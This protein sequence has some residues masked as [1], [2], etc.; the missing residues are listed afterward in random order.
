MTH[1]CPPL[2]PWLHQMVFRVWERNERSLGLTII[3]L[4]IVVM[5]MATLA[6]LGVPLYANALDN[7]VRAVNGG[8]VGLSA[9]F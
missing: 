9:E 5:I 1:I 7:V 6:T 4:L 8:F 3:E 2:R